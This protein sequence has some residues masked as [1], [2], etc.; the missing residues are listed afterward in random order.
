MQ[1]VDLDRRMTEIV[2]TKAANGV[3]LPADQQSAECIA[4]MKLGAGIKMKFTKHN[5]VKF[6]RKMFALANL[7]YEA[8]EP[9]ET[10]Y[11]N[12]IVAKNFD[13]FR[14]DITILA[15]FY[16]SRVRLNGEIRII[17]KSWAFESMDDIEKDRLYNSII[18]VVLS[19][20]LTKYTRAD[21][22]A[23]VESVLRFA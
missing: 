15:G 13:Q 10:T 4:K 11:K 7:A 6:H 12:E 9:L 8:W 18:N 17:A 21:L 3:L 23:V 2:L 14:E 22:D 19:R 16:E 20:I 5:N 1:C